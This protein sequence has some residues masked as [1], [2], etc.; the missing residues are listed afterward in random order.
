[1]DRRFSLH[2]RYP[3]SGPGLPSDHPAEEDDFCSCEDDVDVSGKIFHV[4]ELNHLLTNLRIKFA[5]E[6]GSQIWTYKREPH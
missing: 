4:T 6:L 2:R 1:M 3:V 5:K